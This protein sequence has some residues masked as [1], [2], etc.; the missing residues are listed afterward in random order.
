[1]AMIFGASS[2]VEANTRLK[3]GYSIFDWAMRMR[4][5]P[6]FW[7]RTIS[8][9]NRI[10]EEEIE[11]L[12]EKSCKIA[13]IFD[14]LT[15]VSVSGIDGTDDAMRAVA[16][17]D[18]LSVPA[19]EE[20]AVFAA[21]RDEWSVNHNWMITFAAVLS[22]NGYVPG[23]IGNTDSSKNFNFDRQYG[24]FVHATRDV[25]GYG[26]LIWAT[27]PVAEGEPAEW[28]PFCPSDVETEDVALWRTG[29]VGMGDVTANADYIRDD[30]LLR[31]MF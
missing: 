23:F 30:S 9:D 10:S 8:G 28:S 31:H 29:Y 18:E 14:D 27:E 22:A 25:N 12:R 3:N 11:F 5:F 7:G 4:G 15:E 17:L 21:I 13:L 20:V 1:M 19:G 26:A 6:A 2:T 24:H 16:A